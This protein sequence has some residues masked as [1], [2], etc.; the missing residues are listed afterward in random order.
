M[1]TILERMARIV[2]DQLKVEKSE[3][4]PESS[5]TKDFNADSLDLVQMTMVLEDEFEI[6]VADEEIEKITTV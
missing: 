2:A 4:R 6:R 5:L 3:I 1:A